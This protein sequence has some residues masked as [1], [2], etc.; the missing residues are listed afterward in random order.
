MIRAAMLG[1]IVVVMSGCVG[2]AANLSE[3]ASDIAQLADSTPILK[4]YRMDRASA[5]SSQ[6]W[7]Y[8]ARANGQLS[9]EAAESPV[10]LQGWTELA[11]FESGFA[12]VGMERDGRVDMR[13][14]VIDS[15]QMVTTK[16]LV[17]RMSMVP[18]AERE[19]QPTHFDE[20]MDVLIAQRGD[21]ELRLRF[22]RNDDGS[23]HAPRVDTCEILNS[24]REL[25]TSIREAQ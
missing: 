3:N 10:L 5:A 23:C 19:Y 8:E 6:V 18:R 12:I 14:F 24:A 17:E 20:S 9:M 11:V 21:E 2:R 4:L 25:A 22:G 1:L 13:A 16:R 7:E 15:R